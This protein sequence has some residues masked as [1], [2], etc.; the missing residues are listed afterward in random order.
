[1]PSGIAY[2][3]GSTL[4]LVTTTSRLLLE[5]NRECARVCGSRALFYASVL[6]YKGLPPSL[7]ILSSD[8]LFYLGWD[9]QLAAMVVAVCMW[10]LCRSQVHVG[11]L[12]SA[13]HWII[14]L[15]TEAWAET[16]ASLPGQPWLP[17]A[18][19]LGRL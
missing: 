14:A 13:V 7:A 8:D 19:F 10:R 2:G 18:W 15:A 11:V 1:M 4:S 9:S 16:A 6:S 5:R 17:A 3:G 12:G